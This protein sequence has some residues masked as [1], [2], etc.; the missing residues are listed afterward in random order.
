MNYESWIE[1]YKPVTNSMVDNAAYGGCMFETYGEELEQVKATPVEHVWTIRDEDGA[2]FITA[3]FG[4]VNRIG[5]LITATPWGSGNDFVQLSEEVECDC[6]KED[7]YEVDGELQD[8][9]PDC[10]ECE[11][12][13][14]VTNWLD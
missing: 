8:G 4:W 10:P 13:G 3:G 6:Y 12:Y 2:T 11:G 1:T 5:Y 7:G 14:R 9:N